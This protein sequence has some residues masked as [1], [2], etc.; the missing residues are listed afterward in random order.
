MSNP[1]AEHYANHLAP[2]YSWMVG[3]FAAASGTAAAFHDSLALPPEHGGLV[4][5]LGCGHGVHAV[6]LA[7][8]G[9]E[10]LAIDTSMHLLSELAA[11]VGD[12]PIRVIHDELRNFGTHLNSRAASLITCMG[13]T[14]TQL[15]S[16]E[17]IDELIRQAAAILAP[18]GVLTLSFRDYATHVL[19]GPQR[20]IP[21]RADDRRIRTCFL[22]YQAE[23]VLVHDIWR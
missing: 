12:L 20:F 22:E 13:D 16:V 7:R 10:V 3:D 21:V 23:R 2:I 15:P 4:I 19:T 11:R 14:L 6:P 17:S 1:V 8:R 5:D 9:Y 18:A